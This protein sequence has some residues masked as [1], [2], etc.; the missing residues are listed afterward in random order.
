LEMVASN[1][2]IG[3]G[4][5]RAAQAFVKG[6]ERIRTH[7]LRVQGVP[8]S[9]ETAN[10]ARPNTRREGDQADASVKTPAKPPPAVRKL[11]VCPW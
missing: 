10:L 5:G 1:A 2:R 4:S 11:V 6:L 7:G 9:E 8:T 3:L